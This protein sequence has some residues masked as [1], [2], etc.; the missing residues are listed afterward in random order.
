M[1]EVLKDALEIFRELTYEERLIV[2]ELI[3][4]LPQS[5]EPAADPQEKAVTSDPA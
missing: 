2:H 4:S 1:K 3:R 5:Q